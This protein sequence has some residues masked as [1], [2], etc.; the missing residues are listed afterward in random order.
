MQS[1]FLR[2]S[3]SLVLVVHPRPYP[4]TLELTVFLVDRGNPATL[5][6]SV[7]VSLTSIFCVFQVATQA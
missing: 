7:I 2:S 1:V 4:I 3:R 5:E 6:L